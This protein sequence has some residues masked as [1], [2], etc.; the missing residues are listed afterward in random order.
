MTLAIHVNFN[1]GSVDGQIITSKRWNILSGVLKELCSAELVRDGWGRA[2]SLCTMGFWVRSGAAIGLAALG[3]ASAHAAALSW[4]VSTHAA[5]T[6]S[7]AALVNEPRP[8]L[9]RH[10][11]KDPI[12][13][14]RGAML[15]DPA[16]VSRPARE[17][18]SAVARG[19]AP[20]TKIC[21]T[22]DEGRAVRIQEFIIPS[23]YRSL[24]LAFGVVAGDLTVNSTD[25]RRHRFGGVRASAV[26]AHFD[27]RPTR[28]SGLEAG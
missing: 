28:A 1:H 23:E 18:N 14:A 19:L 15:S 13:R 27:G 16:P 25:V 12:A 26:P 9:R 24:V 8:P 2:M 10:L 6:S 21:A 11:G 7:V 3:S 4:V 17:Q 22:T 5:A 20:A